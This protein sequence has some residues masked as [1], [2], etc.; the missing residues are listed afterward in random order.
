MFKLT[1]DKPSGTL[2][3][4][5]TKYPA[6]SGPHGKGELPSGTY[7]V[8]TRHVV[9]GVG[10]G[11]AYRVMDTAFFIPISPEI[12]T[13][14]SGFGIHPDGRVPGTLGCIGLKGTAAAAFWKRW[15]ETSLQSRPTS[16]SVG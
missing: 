5:I 8:K 3:W 16:I 7:T 1:F 4:G 12:D 15:N 10:L 6:V 9:E 13:K 2:I 14:R 11:S